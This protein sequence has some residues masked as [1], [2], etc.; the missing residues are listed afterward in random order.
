MLKST[1]I[2]YCLHQC[3]MIDCVEEGELIVRKIFSVYFPTYSYAKWNTELS[4]DVTQHF[5]N[6]SKETD[7][8]MVDTFIQELWKL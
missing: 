6:V 8:L 3:G 2:S 4:F 1:L 7:T 5:I